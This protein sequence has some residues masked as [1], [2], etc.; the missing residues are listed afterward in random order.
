MEDS[1]SNERLVW[2][3]RSLTERRNPVE[4]PDKRSPV[5]SEE[6]VE[7][8]KKKSYTATDDPSVEGESDDDVEAHKKKS[9]Q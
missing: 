4:D 9:F 2:D 1:E 7:G 3:S 6:D 5:E 8:H